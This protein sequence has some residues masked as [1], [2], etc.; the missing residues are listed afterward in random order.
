MPSGG[1]TTSYSTVAIVPEFPEAARV[2]NADIGLYTCPG[3]KKAKVTGSMVLDAVGAD[4]TYAIAVKRAGLFFAVGEF[5]TA[6]KVSNINTV[7]I[8]EVGDILTNIGDSGST[9][10]TTDMD[11]SVQEISI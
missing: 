8:L 1:N 10:G 6:G 4:A 11:C 2:T 3:T 9:N 7:V 5:V